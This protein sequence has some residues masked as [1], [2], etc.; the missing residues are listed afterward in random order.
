MKVD[1]FRM[2]KLGNRESDYEDS[3]SYDLEKMKFAIADGVSNSIF[4][5]VWA[6]ALTETFVSGDM[7]LFSGSAGD[8]MHNLI[9]ESRKRWYRSVEWGKLPWFTRN[10]AV[11]GSHSTLLLCHLRHQDDDTLQ[12]RAIAVGDSC[13]FKLRGD[14]IIY[15]FPLTDPAQ[16]NTTPDLVWSGKGHPFPLDSSSRDP[17]VRMM[18]GAVSA[19]DRLVF[20]TDSISVLLLREAHPAAL[21]EEVVEKRFSRSLVEAIDSGRIRNDDITVAVVGF[22]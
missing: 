21:L 11:N 4:S 9:V 2:S 16:F 14:E 8:I 1:Y 12:M 6:R 22:R 7:D 3:F 13:L 15:T 18:D 19:Y 5:D 17:E 10:K 20:A